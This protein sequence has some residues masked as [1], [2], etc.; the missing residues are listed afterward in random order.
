MVMLFNL[1]LPADVAASHR[2]QFSSKHDSEMSSENLGYPH[3]YLQPLH[4]LHE[5][6]LAF[7]GAGTP[8][9]E[10]SDQEQVRTTTAT[11]STIEV[12]ALDGDSTDTEPRRPSAARKKTVYQIAHPVAKRRALRKSPMVLQLR[13][14]EA[15]GRAAPVLEIFRRRAA[16][17]PITRNLSK[18]ASSRDLNAKSGGHQEQLVF[19]TCESYDGEANDDMS[20]DEDSDRRETIASITH[21]STTRSDPEVLLNVGK[22][23]WSV[24]PMPNG[25]YEFSYSDDEGHVNKARWVPKP[26]SERRSI[27]KVRSP[28][29]RSTPEKQFRFALMNPSGRRHPVVGS[30]DRN[31]IEVRDQ[32]VIPDTPVATPDPSS[33]V[34]YNA[35]ESNNQ[36]SYF[37]ELQPTAKGAVTTSEHTKLLMLVT[38]V[39]VAIAEG[40]TQ[41]GGSMNDSVDCLAPQ[42]SMSPQKV[43]MCSSRSDLRQENRSDTPRSFTSTFSQKFGSRRHGHM[44]A[45]GS[46]HAADVIH[47]LEMLENRANS[48][49]SLEPPHTVYGSGEIGPTVS[50]E[51]VTS[52]GPRQHPPSHPGLGI[53]MSGSSL[54]TPP[55]AEEPTSPSFSSLQE[56]LG[57]LNI[58][59]K[60][61]GRQSSDAAGNRS[62]DIGRRGSKSSRKAGSSKKQAEENG[63]RT[64]RLL[65]FKRNKDPG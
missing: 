38:G 20:E 11:S 6:L 8:N 47:G 63:K 21:S 45:P 5:R 46:I 22:E 36:G 61:E 48:G 52:G 56:F 25:G 54:A 19:L 28:L 53:D 16:S 23:K 35:A 2:H 13:R 7:T 3:T 50:A 15:N 62:P 9:A 30:I 40:W 42:A 26:S 60:R 64:R 1:G 43:R 37:D 57:R 4:Y 18:K 27:L 10:S 24:A 51:N 17:R 14:I 41:Y 12:A 59:S 33:P 29:Q 55:I 65:G 34:G 58:G 31:A 44:I 49:L 39:W 32:F